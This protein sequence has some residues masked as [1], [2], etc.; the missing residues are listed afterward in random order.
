MC[1]VSS[2]VYPSSASKSGNQAK[3]LLDYRPGNES[4]DCH[5]S[6]PLSTI[7]SPQHSFCIISI[8]FPFLSATPFSPG[9]I[10]CWIVNEYF[11]LE[12]RAFQIPCAAVCFSFR[13]R[14]CARKKGPKTVPHHEANQF[15]RIC[16]C[17]CI[18][19]HIAFLSSSLSPSLTQ[20]GWLADYSGSICSPNSVF[21]FWFLCLRV[22][23][24]QW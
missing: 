22:Q 4:L 17:W 21:W 7:S 16:L 8:I 6:W 18:C 11:L 3:H 19:L 24:Y 12:M 2:L 9:F 20:T 15:V 5:F 14:K 23:V 1:P 13:E 10:I